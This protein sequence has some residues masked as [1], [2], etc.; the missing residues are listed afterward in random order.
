MSNFVA[1]M[2]AAGIQPLEP[3]TDRLSGGDLVRFRSSGDKPGRQNAWAVLHL[4]GIPAGAFGSY[5][6]GIEHRWRSESSAGVS[7]ETD[8]EQAKQRQAERQTQRAAMQQERWR[9]A[10]AEAEDIWRSAD[11]VIGDH[12]YAVRK[13]LDGEA[14]RRLRGDLIA[15]MR[16]IDGHLLNVQRIGSDGQKRFL[17]GGLTA[18]LFW[19]SG[20]PNGV[21]CI[22]EGVATMV[23][24]RVATKYAV[25]AALSAKNVEPVARQIRARCPALDIIVC[26]DDDA[27]HSENLGINVARA[28]ASAVSGRVALPPR[29]L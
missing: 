27:H 8:H 11:V 26:A 7:C 28:A 19:L 10:A 22:G 3:L 6:L 20:R 16:D 25:A 17:S 23:A 9:Q 14:L 21:I 13:G 1:A 24:V 5:R 2:E 18:G 15:P 12:P 29:S 4:D